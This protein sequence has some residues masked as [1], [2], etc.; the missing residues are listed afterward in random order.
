[1]TVVALLG[2]C[3]SNTESGSRKVTVRMWV[4][5]LLQELRDHELY[6]K[7]KEGFRKEHPEIDVQIETLPWTGRQQKMITAVAGNRAPDAVYLNMDLI[8]RF[9]KLGLLL[10]LDP[11]VPETELA[12]YD[13]LVRE[14]VA[15][16]G[17]MY[18]LPILRTVATGI[19]NKELFE[20]A[21]LD[22]EKPPATWDE[23]DKVA[24]KLTKDT[25]GDGQ[26]DQWGLGYV[27]GSDSLNATFWP[28]LWQAGGNVLTPDGK[29]ATFAGPEG[30]EA[31][32]FLTKQFKAGRIP[33]S[34]L[35]LGSN[36]FASGRL[37]YWFGAS[38]AELRQ[39]RQD[40]PHLKIGTG[41]ALTNKKRVGYST[42]AGYGVFKSSKHPQETVLWLRYMTRLDN[43]KYLCRETSYF[44]AK[45]TTET[46]YPDDPIFATMEKEAPYCRPD[47][48]TPYARQ[49]A[50][51]LIPLIQNSVLG[52][53]TPQEALDTAAKAVNEMLE[54]N[55]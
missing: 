24:E 19:Y 11:L 8:A 43:M 51:T 1:M 17:Q 26:I 30:L 50:Q 18:I 3:R 34:Y 45:R 47:I 14:G 16:R 32:T 44:P 2:G 52:R 27:M 53:T 25:D 55:D 49:I 31:L 22:P 20:K 35:N 54:R 33:H 12:E 37:G 23:L 29:H 48:A 6:A 28:L 41:L 7:L 10:P 39:L 40:A 5:P 13:P 15:I 38:S 46:L 42:I 21:G 36:E 4:F 9:E